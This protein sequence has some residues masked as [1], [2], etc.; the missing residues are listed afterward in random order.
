MKIAN[1]F[2]FNMLSSLCIL[3]LMSNLFIKREKKI[4]LPLQKK[5]FSLLSIFFN[6]HLTNYSSYNFV[7]KFFCEKKRKP[8]FLHIL[9]CFYFP[10]VNMEFSGI[11][12]KKWSFICS[13]IFFQLYFFP[14][15]KKKTNYG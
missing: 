10:S 11:S 3:N 14:K 9:S 12:R 5:T 4:F 7:D 1:I 8:L 15:L 2:L 13:F 6:S